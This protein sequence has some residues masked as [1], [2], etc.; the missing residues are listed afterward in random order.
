MSAIYLVLA[1]LNLVLIGL[2]PRIFFDARGRKNAM[3]WATATPFVA[4][5]VVLV[6]CFTGVWQ[7]WYLPLAAG[8]VLNQTIAVPFACASIALI[9][10]TIGT[11]RVP[12]A[13]WHQDND[14]PQS[15]VTYGAYKY[16]RHPFYSAFLLALIGTLVACPHP[17]TL[18][19]LIYTAL[20]LR[21]TAGKEEHKLSNSEFGDEY[22]SYLARTGRF[23]PRLHGGA[24]A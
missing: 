14:A 16:V 15:I 5:G 8:A 21:Y 9:A 3:W 22:R 1:G 24:S 2:L 6:L 13:L 17:A 20:M 18:A 4:A 7:P 12:L 23:L 19:C 10:Y 11:H